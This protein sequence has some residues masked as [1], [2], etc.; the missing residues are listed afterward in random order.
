MLAFDGVAVIEV[1]TD[2]GRLTV[3]VMALLWT[4]WAEA[5]IWEVPTDTPLASPAEFTVATLVLELAQTNVR[6]LI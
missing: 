3:R 2:G 6:P 1:R 4:P 5:L